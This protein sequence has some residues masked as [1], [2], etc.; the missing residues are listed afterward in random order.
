M[1]TLSWSQSSGGISVRGLHA[2]CL[3]IKAKVRIGD[4]GRV[5]RD[6]QVIILAGHRA[7]YHPP[8]HAIGAQP[9][10]VRPLHTPPVQ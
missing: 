10:S 7:C 4:I 1:T 5:I 2:A 9:P 8:P 3:P 6:V